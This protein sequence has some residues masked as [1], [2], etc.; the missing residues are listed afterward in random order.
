MLAI[1]NK[2]LVNPPQE[3]Y[4]PASLCSSRKPKLPGEIVKDFVSSNPSKAFTMSFGDA[5]LLAC[6]S[7]GNSYPR[8]Q[9][10]FCGLD[11]IYCIFLGS[12]NN[13]CSLNKQYGLSKS[14]NEAMFIIEAYRTLRDR[15]PYPAHK[16]LQDMDGRFGF[17]VYDSKAGQVFAALGANEGAELFWGVAADGSVVISD[18]LEVIKGSCAKS[19]APFPP[20]CMFHSEQGLMS[21]EHPSRKMKAFPRIDSEGTMCGANFKV[22][23]HSRIGSMPRV[24]SEANWALGGS[25]A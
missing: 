7:Q 23:V 25:R 20:A 24:G 13:L 12:L 14:T 17:V 16:V 11:G 19:F 21:F 10:L 2:G 1:F 18:N 9:R 6:I 3:L 22:D 15:G 8:H 5:A 4:S